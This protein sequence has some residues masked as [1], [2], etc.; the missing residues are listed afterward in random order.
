MVD[1]RVPTSYTL[2][3]VVNLSP[4]KGPQIHFTMTSLSTAT[5]APCLLSTSTS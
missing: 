3:D 2:L 1:Q 5:C 4:H